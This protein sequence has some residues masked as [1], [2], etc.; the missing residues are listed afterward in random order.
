MRLIILSNRL[1]V[2]VT[3]GNGKLVFEPSA[4]GLATG[5]KS[6]LSDLN[7]IDYLWVGWPGGGPYSDQPDL[8]ELL[9][10]KYNSHPVFV[11]EKNMD[12]FYHGFCNKTLWPLFHYFPSLT[13][14]DEQLWENY[15]EVNRRFADEVLGIL[16]DGDVLWIHDYHF[17]LV[18]AMIK[19]ERPEIPVGLFLHIPFPTF[20]IFRLLPRKWGKEILSGM[21]GADLVGFHT[22]DFMHYFLRCVLR[23][24][25]LNHDMGVVDLGHKYTR[26]GAFP[27]GINFEK[28]SGASHIS[29]VK[30]ERDLLDKEFRTL[31]VIFSVDRQD[32]TKGILNRLEGFE[33]FL[34]KNPFWRG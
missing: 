2:T 16:R 8:R 18:A 31:K 25:G 14:F 33:L 30:K 10:E 19:K 22:Y 29:S 1:Q 9:H 6:W 7:D 3:E 17:L 11:E 24:M 15:R 32:Y 34:E 28:Y 20:E 4:G 5:I 27:M 12:L 26:V 13:V 23:I 21:L